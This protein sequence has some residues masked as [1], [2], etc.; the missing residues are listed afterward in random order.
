MEQQPLMLLLFA[1]GNIAKE[2]LEHI[3][4]CDY[5]IRGGNEAVAIL[6]CTNNQP[7]EELKAALRNIQSFLNRYFKVTVSI[8]IGDISHGRKNVPSSYTSAQQYVK[9]RLIYGKE[10]ILEAIAT[11]PHMMSA[12]SYPS[13]FEKKLVDAVQSGKPEPIR[14]AIE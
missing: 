13:A 11:R 4:E 2:M 6:Q 3:G 10:S 5:L 1:L 12:V 9:Y 14:D 8:G 7:P